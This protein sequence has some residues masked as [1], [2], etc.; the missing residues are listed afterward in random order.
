MTTMMKHRHKKTKAKTSNRLGFDPSLTIRSEP[1]LPDNQRIDCDLTTRTYRADLKTL[2]VE[3]RSIECVI[4]TESRVKVI[5]WAR[6]E[7]I[8][9]ILR[10]DGLVLPAQVPLLDTHNRYS[11]Q[12]QFGSTRD[13]RIDGQKLL[14][15]NCY[16]SSPDVDHAWTLCREG[17]LTDNSIG[18]HVTN[19]VIIE[20]GKSADVGGRSYTAAPTMAL[21]ITLAWAI[22]ENSVCPIGADPK[23]KTRNQPSPNGQLFNRKEESMKE[24]KEWLTARGLEHDTLSEAQRTAL[25]ADFDAECQRAEAAKKAPEN[26]PQEPSQRTE[27]P[28][29]GIDQARAQQIA[30]EAVRAELAR[31]NAIRTEAAGLGIEE[32]DIARCI[33]DPAMS[34][35]KARG[36][37]LTLIRQRN[38]N[39]VSAGPGILVPD[40]S[41]DQRM[42]VD[43]VLMRSGAEQMVLADA[44][45]GAKRAEMA[46][47][48]RDMSMVDLCRHAILLDGGQVPSGRDDLIRTALN[49]STL[50]TVLGAVYHK[51]LLK[52]YESVVDTWNKW[53]S[54]GNLTDFKTHTRVRLTG[55]GGLEKV[56]DGGDLKLG[57]ETEEK[58]T[59]KLDTYGKKDRYGRQA[60]IN[61]DLDVLTKVP[62]RRGRDGKLLIS[63]LVYAV[64]LANG[65][66]ED[67][68]AMFHADHANFNANRPL[69]M[70]NLEYAITQFKKQKDKAG[71]RIKVQPVNLLVPVE[72][73]WAAKKMINSTLIVMAGTAA[74]NTV[75]GDSNV[76]QN[77]LD[78]LAEELLSGDALTGYSAS[79]WYL[80]GDPN[81]VDTLEVGFLNGRQV[82][83]IHMNPKASDMYIEFE[84]YIDVGVGKMDHRGLQKNTQ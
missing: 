9:E 29:V 60:I 22:R 21:R 15:R 65:M 57:S 80:T 16:S 42:L 38:E 31:Q 40:R 8:E 64:L 79:S 6:Y 24:F 7:V 66:M 39:T 54:I 75:Q 2:D 1:V 63:Q 58:A 30:D 32:K 12:T 44:A 27:A 49:T 26:E 83:V 28:S 67:G 45:E 3:N 73:E 37:F 23:A 77:A 25:Q 59:N 50:P 13:F 35:E 5:D 43:V 53:C 62:Q 84:S 76:L 10:M 46:D 71:K 14:A 41:V 4:A 78:V 11:V 17:H 61:D 56:G 47:R 74:A 34:V 48:H 36:E 33:M 69:T 68:V 51:S 55:E 20:A 70:D 81:V 72:L 52:G 18:Y 19:A 82:P